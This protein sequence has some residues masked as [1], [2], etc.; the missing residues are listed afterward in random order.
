MSE[1][2]TVLKHYELINMLH[3]YS[4]VSIPSLPSP[5]STTTN[6]DSYF[7]DEASR[8][9]T[10]M[11]NFWSFKLH[12]RKDAYWN[13]LK[14]QGHEE[15]YQNWI[16]R[17]KVIVPRFLS[18]KRVYKRTCRSESCESKRAVL[19]DFKTE[20]ELRDLKAKQ[21]EERYKQLDEEME[22]CL[23]TKGSERVVNTLLQIWK[24]E[25]SHK[26]RYP[27]KYGNAVR[28]GWKPM[29]QTFFKN[30]GIKTRFFKTTD[31]WAEQ[32]INETQTFPRSART[33]Q[34]KRT[35]QTP[36]SRTKYRD[37]PRSRTSKQHKPKQ[38]QEQ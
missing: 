22:R 36:P 5:Q 21:Y 34:T 33:E 23:Q 15:K 1:R 10:T 12:K 27:T 37:T 6:T 14:N 32:P 13:M 18:E 2:C 29:K 30:T 7:E 38:S 3:T 28:N 4:V 8:I 31:D 9:K 35:T 20:I 17:E 24:A 11:S 19:S 26:K 25:T 16:E